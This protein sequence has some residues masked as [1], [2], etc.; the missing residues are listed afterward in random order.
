MTADARLI[1]IM[2][3]PTKLYRHDVMAKPRAVCR[4]WQHGVGHLQPLADYGRNE[5]QQLLA[6]HRRQHVQPRGGAL[7]DVPAR[8]VLPAALALRV[9][10]VSCMPLGVD[11]LLTANARNARLLYWR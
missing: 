3:L 1:Q 8:R 5:G 6:K 10:A 4:Q 11:R 2:R 9:P 7:A